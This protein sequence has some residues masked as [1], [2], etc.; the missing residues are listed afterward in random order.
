M[1]GSRRDGRCTG[2]GHDWHAMAAGPRVT[3][4]IDLSTISAGMPKRA[5]VNDADLSRYRLTLHRGIRRAGY[6]RVPDRAGD[7]TAKLVV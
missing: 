1:I 5:A 6:G 4:S 2:G 7:R 3:F